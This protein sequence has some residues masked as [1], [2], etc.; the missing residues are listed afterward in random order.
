MWPWRDE[1][2]AIVPAP[3]VITPDPL[4][5][6]WRYWVTGVGRS[7]WMFVVVDWHERPPRIVTAFN[8]RKGPI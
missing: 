4:G 3:D 6:R 7:R 2:L 5:G 1:V 8:R